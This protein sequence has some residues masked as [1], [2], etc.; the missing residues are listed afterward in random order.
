[1]RS[2]SWVRS[3]RPCRQQAGYRPERQANEPEHCDE[4]HDRDDCEQ[5]ACDF[6]GSA[7][8]WK[9]SVPDATPW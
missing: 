6:H 3:Y 9:A 7:S 2:R 1:M 5:F 4:G 8:M